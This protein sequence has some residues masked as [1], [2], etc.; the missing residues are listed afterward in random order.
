[1]KKKLKFTIFIQ[2]YNDVRLNYK[3]SSNMNLLYE[4]NKLKLLEGELIFYKKS[5][6][7]TKEIIW[8]IKYHYLN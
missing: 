3:E 7:N 5:E 8:I 2:V 4:K 6:N 1:L